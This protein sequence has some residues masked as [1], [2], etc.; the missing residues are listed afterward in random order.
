[1]VVRSK[2]AETVHVIID[3]NGEAL[4]PIV[5]NGA[6][7]NDY[8]YIGNYIKNM[9]EKI[10]SETEEEAFFLTAEDKPDGNMQTTKSSTSNT[11]SLEGYRARGNVAQDLIDE[12]MEKTGDD[13]NVWFG[14][15]EPDTK[16]RWYKGTV[17]SGERNGDAQNSED[18]TAEIALGS[19]VQ[20]IPAGEATRAV[21]TDK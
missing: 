17:T 5:K 2:N 8:L 21:K 14:I 3:Y 16:Q 10:D 1:M 6:T 13:A 12:K 19:P 4:P 7:K 15:I 9:A 11:I 18:W 20:I